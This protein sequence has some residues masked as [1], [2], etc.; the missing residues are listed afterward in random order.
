MTD[1]ASKDFYARLEVSKEVESEA[2]IKAYRKLSRKCGSPS[3]SRAAQRIARPSGTPRAC[4]RARVVTRLTGAVRPG[5]Y[6]P[7]KGG[8]EKDFQ[9]LGEAHE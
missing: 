3:L 7:D 9:A 5:R 8:N 6:H 4:V 1:L 2:V